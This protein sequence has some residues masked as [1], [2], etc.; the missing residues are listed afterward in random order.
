[1]P[2]REDG[3]I[4]LATWKVAGIAGAGTIFSA[5]AES[6][7]MTALTAGLTALVLVLKAYSLILDVRR[8][9]DSGHTGTK[10]SRGGCSENE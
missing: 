6:P 10:T 4:S 1:M 7:A 8:K 2:W 9:G 5:M 3:I